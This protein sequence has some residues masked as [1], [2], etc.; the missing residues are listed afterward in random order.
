MFSFSSL[1]PKEAPSVSKSC[2]RTLGLAGP[3]AS[4]CHG[5]L[6]ANTALSWAWVRLDETSGGT[7]V[8]RDLWSFPGSICY[9]AAQWFSG[10]SVGA[11][12]DLSLCWLPTTPHPLHPHLGG[13]EGGGDETALQAGA[14]NRDLSP[15]GGFGG[16]HA[17]LESAS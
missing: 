13:V 3:L 9:S 11:G 14:S 5:G 8:F 1:T 7:F 12:A 2:N 15:G 6:A 10:T 4:K 16:T 17:S